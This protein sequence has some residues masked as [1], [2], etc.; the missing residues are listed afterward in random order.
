MK[1]YCCWLV[2]LLFVG[3]AFQSCEV[4]MTMKFQNRLLFKISFGKDWTSIIYGKPMCQI[5]QI[6]AST[7]N[8][9]WIDFF[10]DIMIPQKFI[11]K[12]I[13]QTQKLVPRILV[14]PLIVLVSLPM[15]I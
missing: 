1:K 3:T 2:L 4:Q 15:N 7:T 5:Y 11:S 9:I 13:K 8:P 6:H 14:M 10:M 12:F